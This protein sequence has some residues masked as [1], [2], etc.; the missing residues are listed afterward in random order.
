MNKEK[1]LAIL[2]G[3]IQDLQKDLISYSNEED[4]KGVYY[5]RGRLEGLLQL[6]QLIHAGRLDIN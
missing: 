5:T 2:Q 1:T 4:E 3:T 6:V